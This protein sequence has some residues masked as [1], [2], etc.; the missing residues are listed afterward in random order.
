M[1]NQNQPGTQGYIQNSGFTNSPSRAMSAQYSQE[2]GFFG[3]LDA[4][5]AREQGKKLAREA[6]AGFESVL[7]DANVLDNMLQKSIQSME[8]FKTKTKLTGEALKEHN[9]YYKDLKDSQEK[10]SKIQSS[11]SQEMRKANPDEKKILDLEIKRVE[12]QAKAEKLIAKASIQKRIEVQMVEKENLLKEKSVGY[13]EQVEQANRNIYKLKQDI[14]DIE[15]DTNS[16]YDEYLEKL[17]KAKKLL[18]QSQKTLKKTMSDFKDSVNSVFGYI[19]DMWDLIDPSKRIDR[20][21]LELD[22]FT[23]DTYQLANA[24]GTDYSQGFQSFKNGL[25]A[26]INSDNAF[27][28]DQINTAMKDLT[29]ITFESKEAMKGMARDFTYAKEYMGMQNETLAEMYGMQ[30][31]TNDDTYFKKTMETVIGLQKSGISISEEQLNQTVKSSMTLTDALLANGMSYEDVTDFQSSLTKMMSVADATMG[32]GAGENLKSMIESIVTGGIDNLA[33]LG[34]TALNGYMSV[35]KGNG[36]AND[37]LNAI[38]NS[39][40]ANIYGNIYSQGPSWG[41]T[42]V[43]SG[44]VQFGG[45]NAGLYRDFQNNFGDYTRVSEDL[46]QATKEQ[47]DLEERINEVVK[48]LPDAY[49]DANALGEAQL[50]T[51]WQLISENEMNRKFWESSKKEILTVINGLIAVI[52]TVH[53]LA[54]YANTAALNANTV[55]QGGS[56]LKSLGSKGLGKLTAFGTA[57]NTV[58]GAISSK[59]GGG[60]LGKTLGVAA[61]GA[62]VAGGVVAAYDMAKTGIDVGSN[63]FVDSSGARIE[64][65]GG[66]KSGAAAAF[67]GSDVKDSK[68]GNIGGGALSGG[69]KGAAVGAAIGTVIPV[70][71]T[72]VGAAVG[73]VVGVVGGL[74]G[75]MHKDSIRKQEEQR[76]LME[77]QLERQKE[78][79]ANTKEL[80]GLR[81][82]VLMDRYSDMRSGPVGGPTLHSEVHSPKTMNSIGGATKGGAEDPYR[83][84]SRK[85]GTLS[86]HDASD[87]NSSY[88]GVSLNPFKFTSRYGWR[89][90]DGSIQWHSGIDFS[91]YR[92]YDQPIGA[93]YDG[94]VVGLVTGYDKDGDTANYVAVYHPGQGITGLYYH[95]S[96]AADGLKVGD[97]VKA[98]NIIGYQGNSGHSYGAHLHFQVNRGEGIKWGQDIDPGPFVT[99]GIF[100]PGGPVIGVNDSESSSNPY[101]SDVSQTKDAMAIMPTATPGINIGG[102]G[103]PD[104]GSRNIQEFRSKSIEGKLDMLNNTLIGMQDKQRE[105]DKILSALTNTP[106]YNYGV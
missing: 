100:N 85:N 31:R 67:A 23:K 1:N 9:S 6:L 43:G 13:E 87:D 86:A 36:N 99:T 106:I 78:T 44:Q 42:L 2:A 93:A 91:K 66:L 52:T 26:E 34:P 46:S 18:E 17:E 94:K 38:M 49:K 59:L 50:A 7:K 14:N 12:A 74:L 24:W 58:G 64:G 35:L 71:G 41:T 28:P 21:T 39:E 65:T 90:L 104:G 53:T 68:L 15:S 96:K 45:L 89:K 83:G 30:L 16:Q 55:A 32:K 70:V 57:K 88:L 19:D 48:R 61:N 51:N 98:G 81:D 80:Q 101:V 63:G 29:Q 10:I 27:N 103:G 22:K 72:A 75:G 47:T 20:W 84:G 3:A 79:A 11:I 97:E 95:M 25:M 76:K 5:T 82:A 40:G 102:V 4:K 69:L 8:V 37:L 62:V 56:S 54:V 33:E 77:Q 105:Q 73:G 92:D 60:A